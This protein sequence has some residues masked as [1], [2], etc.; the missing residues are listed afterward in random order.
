VRRASVLV[1]AYLGEV[2]RAARGGDWEPT[3]GELRPESYR[4]SLPGGIKALPVACAFERLSGRRLEQPSDYAR[5]IT[6]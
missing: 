2:L 1:G 4:V 6:G 3:R 5:R